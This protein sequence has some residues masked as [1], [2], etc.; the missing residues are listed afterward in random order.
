MDRLRLRCYFAGQM[1]LAQFG[2]ITGEHY[3]TVSRQLART[4]REVRTGVERELRESARL[5]EAEIA[6]AF[7]FA[8]DDPAELNLQEVF[9]MRVSRKNPTEERS[10]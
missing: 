4:R 8:L 6:R 10:K 1:T 5:S 2:L 7:E 9:A 3:A